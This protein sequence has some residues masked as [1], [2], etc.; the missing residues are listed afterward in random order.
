MQREKTD[1][2]NRR[3][4]GAV[5]VGLLIL[6][7][8]VL[9]A[10]AIGLRHVLADTPAKHGITLR[11]PD[12]VLDREFHVP[13]EDPTWV[14]GKDAKHMRPDDAVVGYLDGD[15]AWAIPW[16]I[17]DNHHAANLEL[18]G[19]PVAIALCERCSSASA[20]DPVFDGV[21]HHFRV[22]GLWNGTIVTRDLET[23]SLWAPFLGRAL[24]GPLE[25]HEMKRLRLDQAKWSEWLELHP[26]TLV[27]L[28]TEDQRHGHGEEDF[29]PGVPILPG[30]MRRSIQHPDSRLGEFDVVLGVTIGKEM[31]AYSM[32]RLD[33]AG[34]VVRDT[35][36][37]QEIVVLHKKDSWLAAAFA[38]EL[39]G[40]KLELTVHGDAIVDAKS[41]STFN[42]AGDAVS[43]PLAGKKLAPVAYQLEEW[44]V[45]STQ[46]AGTTVWSTTP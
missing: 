13:L 9:V 8:G 41:G 11:D 2:S 20:F 10:S 24:Y 23:G 16:W 4:R 45:W 7:I 6:G 19:R 34:P 3:R 31:R 28:G 1:E 38:R 18:N 39:D 42:L 26:D 14:A 40:Q 27:V 44:Y 21:R 30:G 25:G 17:L 32:K 43:G 36:G 46:H 35:L 33:A 5:Q 29:E 22:C 12:S 37:G 15:L